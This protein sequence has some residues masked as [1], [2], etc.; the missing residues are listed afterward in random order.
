MAVS[1]RVRFE[2]FKRDL[3]TCR[4]CG[5]RPPDVVLECDHVHPRSDGGSDEMDN[6]AT[7]CA[8]CNRGKAAKGLRDTAPAVDELERLAAIQEMSERSRL[9]RAEQLQAERQAL[10]ITEAAD[11]VYWWWEEETGEVDAYQEKSVELFLRRG[12]P[13]SQ[14]RMAVDITTAK[15]LAGNFPNG[16]VMWRYFCGVCWGMLR[17]MEGES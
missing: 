3:F 6:L 9:L 13:L 15:T 1:K 17:K 10:A 14:I 11:Q 4:Y 8:D 5:R 16:P 12:L 2:V 7:A